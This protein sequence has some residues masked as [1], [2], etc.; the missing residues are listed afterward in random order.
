MVRLG[1]DLPQYYCF[2]NKYNYYIKTIIA[3][4]EIIIYF[5]FYLF[6]EPLAT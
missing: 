4:I 3:D 5:F 2:L 1:D 6:K